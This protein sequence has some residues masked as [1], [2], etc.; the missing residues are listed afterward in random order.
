MRPMLAALAVIVGLELLKAPQM[1]LFLSIEAGLLHLLPRY[2]W[3]EITWLGDFRILVCLLAPWLILRPRALA[4]VLVAAP[5]ASFFSVSLKTWFDVR[6][7]YEVLPPIQPEL[8]Q[9]AG[10]SSFPSGHSLT[11]AVFIAIIYAVWIAPAPDSRQRRFAMASLVALGVA[12]LCSRMALQAHWPLDVLAG[13]CVGWW[14]GSLAYLLTSLGISEGAQR[15]HQV[16]ATGLLMTT[17]VYVCLHAVQDMPDR[18]IP[19]IAAASVWIFVLW[20]SGRMLFK[21][22][23]ADN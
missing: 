11:V 1:T 10:N 21:R 8:A 3:E 2:L 19:W 7:P 5:L 22:Q 20:I 4:S 15:V 16:M 9:A 13:W 18:Q 6:R 12:V 17:S 14:V 23:T